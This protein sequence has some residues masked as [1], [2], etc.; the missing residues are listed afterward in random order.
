MLTDALSSSF[1]PN[2]QRTSPPPPVSVSI[3][4]TTSKSGVGSGGLPSSSSSGIETAQPTG[5]QGRPRKTS[6]GGKP[7]KRSISPVRVLPPFAPSTLLA[8]PGSLRSFLAP[9]LAI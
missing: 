3:P 6:V 2:V 5:T 9:S 8:A 1:K 7:G 4:M